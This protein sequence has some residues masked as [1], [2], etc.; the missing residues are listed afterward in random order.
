MF[1]HPRPASPERARR[2]GEGGSTSS[3]PN[4]PAAGKLSYWQLTHDRLQHFEVPWREG[5]DH[6]DRLVK[7]LSCVLQFSLGTPGAGLWV[8]VYRNMQTTPQ[9]SFQYL[10]TL[11]SPSNY[12]IVLV[13]DL[14]DLLAM[15]EHL[16]PIV[17]LS[18]SS[19]QEQNQ[20]TQKHRAAAAEEVG[21]S[22]TQH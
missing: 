5:G 16:A 11:N 19:R 9:L 14:P 8:D 1:S 22:G 15:L 7:A 21:G 17:Q 13:D 6:F 4:P 20:L 10:V 3:V 12:N 18:M 2:T